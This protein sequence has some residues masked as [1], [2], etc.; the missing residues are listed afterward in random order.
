RRPGNASL[1]GQL[2][3]LDRELGDDQFSAGQ[4][5]G[6]VHFVGRALGDVGEGQLPPFAR[7]QG[8]GLGGQLIN[9]LRVGLGQLQLERDRGRVSRPGA[10]ALVNKRRVGVAILRC[11]RHRATL[12]VGGLDDAQAT[13]GLQGASPG[14]EQFGADD[15]AGLV[16]A[17]RSRARLFHILF[18][19]GKV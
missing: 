9:A 12:V 3:V 4:N 2:P 13:D 6:E 19:V 18:S 17:E 11:P 16:S 8:N 5:L 10:A 1:Y 14:S 15:G 7:S